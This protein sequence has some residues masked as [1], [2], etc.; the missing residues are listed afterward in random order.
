MINYDESQVHKQILLVIVE[1]LTKLKA[2]NH[3]KAEDI[4]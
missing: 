1:I 2:I 3:E 4:L